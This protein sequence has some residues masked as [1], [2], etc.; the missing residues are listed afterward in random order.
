MYYAKEFKKNN[1]DVCNN[2]IISDECR[3]NMEW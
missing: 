2:Y 3:N 1:I